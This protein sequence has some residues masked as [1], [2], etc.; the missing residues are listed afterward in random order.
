MLGFARLYAWLAVCLAQ[1]ALVWRLWKLGLHRTYRFFFLYLLI[2]LVRSVVLYQLVGTPNVYALLYMYS[3]PLLWVLHFVIVWE[4][5]HQVLRQYPGIWTLGRLVLG[6][7]L[8][9]ALLISAL[10]VAPNIGPAQEKYPILLS[11]AVGE[12]AIYSAV[13]VYLL[14]MSGFLGWYPVSLDSN[15]VL[16]GM[17]YMAYFLSKAVGFLVRNIYGHAVTPAMNNLLLGV[18]AA[19]FLVWLLGLRQ[20]GRSRELVTGHRWNPEEAKRLLGQLEALNSTLLGKN[21]D[22]KSNRLSRRDP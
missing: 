2:D 11:F 5:Y 9:A 12:R 16:H 6:G 20:P 4:L 21:G 10:T 18:A 19:C 22:A 13:V 1:A 7:G 3:Q 17:V 15:T 8:A 14:L